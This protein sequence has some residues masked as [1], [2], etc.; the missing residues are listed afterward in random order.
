MTSHDLNGEGRDPP[1]IYK[2]DFFST[3]TG[4]RGFRG[5]SFLGRQTLAHNNIANK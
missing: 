1:H 5:F 4:V 2:S 3:K